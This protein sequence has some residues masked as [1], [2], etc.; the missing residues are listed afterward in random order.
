MDGR[1]WTG[2]ELARAANVTPSTAS[3]HLKRLVGGAL[4]AVVPQ[5]RHRYYKLASPEVANALESLMVLAPPSKPRHPTARALDTALRQARTCYDHLAGVLGVSLADALRKRGA[6]AFDEHGVRCTPAGV[7]LFAELGIACE[8]LGRRP[9][10]RACLDW[11]ERRPHIAGV[12]GAALC[13]HALDNQWVR[14][15]AATRALDV[16]A[17]GIVAFREAFGIVWRPQ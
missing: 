15:R 9:L 3:A 2:R 8:P 17:S 5:G 7:A 16:T 12:V 11:S 13:R 4:L 1:A 14:R 10:C 6:I